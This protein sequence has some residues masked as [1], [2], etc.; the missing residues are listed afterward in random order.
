MLL[1]HY[2]IYYCC[3]VA[4]LCPTLWDPMNCSTPGFP[5]LHYLPEFAQTL[6]HWVSDAIQPSHPLWP[7]SPP[8]LRYAVS[9]TNDHFYIIP[10]AS[11]EKDWTENK[12]QY[13]FCVIKC[14]ESL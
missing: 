2:S 11:E 3:S 5:A 10:H 7:S 8:S 9:K 13:L 6:V 14:Y 1:L 12:H 4:K